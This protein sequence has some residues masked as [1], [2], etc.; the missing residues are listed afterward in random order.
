MENG[1]RITLLS[2][3]GSLCLAVEVVVLKVREVTLANR[4]SQNVKGGSP[5]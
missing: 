4:E 2:L 1:G 3:V 5:V